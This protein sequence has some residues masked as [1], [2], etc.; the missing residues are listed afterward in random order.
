MELWAKI[1]N[2]YI[3]LSCFIGDFYRIL[4][5]LTENGSKTKASISDILTFAK[6]ERV[7]LVLGFATTIV[8]GLSFP[9]FSVLYGRFFLNLSEYFGSTKQDEQGRKH[10]FDQVLL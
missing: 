8:C 2:L 3:I 5:D 1:F 4:P 7:K 9:L 6:P 10:I